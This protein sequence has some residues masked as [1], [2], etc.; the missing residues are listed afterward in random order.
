MITAAEVRYGDD[1]E[2]V[3]SATGPPIHLVHQ[4]PAIAITSRYHLMGTHY[5]V[6]EAVDLLASLTTAAQGP[7][8]GGSGSLP[9]PW[10]T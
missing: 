1:G 2:V 7:P 6:S 5:D 8:D 4:V 10:T 9:M 3:A